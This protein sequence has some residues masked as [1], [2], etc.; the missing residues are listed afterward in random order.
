MFRLR[1]HGY[2]E[3][4]FSESVELLKSEVSCYLINERTFTLSLM[5]EWIKPNYSE[6]QDHN[7]LLT[8]VGQATVKTSD[9]NN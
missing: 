3:K 1:Y 9:G 7:L 2:K 8:F 4:Y 6:E 5:Y